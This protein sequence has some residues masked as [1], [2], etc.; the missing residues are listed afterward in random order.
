MNWRCVRYDSPG[1]VEH[2]VDRWAAAIK[3]I[4]EEHKRVANN[5]RADD[6]DAVN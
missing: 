5:E 3:A 6:E 2:V 4:S 1:E